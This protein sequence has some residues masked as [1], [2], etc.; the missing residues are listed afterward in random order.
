MEASAATFDM[1]HKLSYS[2]A[3]LRIGSE[4]QPAELLVDTGS[5][6]TWTFADACEIDDMDPE[7]WAT[8]NDFHPASSTTFKRLNDTHHI[9]Y[10]DNTTISGDIV[11]DT[12][13]F[14]E[15]TDP[16]NMVELKADDMRFMLKYEHD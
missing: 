16:D 2:S 15:G 5:S 3:V 14:G 9:K 10:G 4:R 8:R 12:I 6:W 1:Y 13:S 7:C 11:T